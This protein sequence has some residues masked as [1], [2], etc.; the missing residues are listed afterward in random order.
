M[1]IDSCR[2]SLGTRPTP[3]PAALYLASGARAVVPGL[4]G[5][6]YLPIQIPRLAMTT[7]QLGQVVEA[8]AN[9]HRQRDRVAPLE[10]QSGKRWNDQLRFRSVFADLEPYD[11]DCYPFVVHTLER[12]P[13][14]SREQRDRAVREAG[15]NT[16]LL[17]SADVSIDLLTDSGT[18]AMS[19]DQWAAYD[20]ARA[21]PATSD[22]YLHFVKTFRE[23]YGYEHIIPTHQGRAAEHILSQIMIRSGP[24]RARQHVLH[25]NEGAPGIGRGRVRR[26]HRRSG[27]RSG[28]RI[29][30][31]G[32]HR[33]TKAPNLSSNGMARA[34]W[35]TS[36]S[37]T[38]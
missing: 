10:L 30:V 36:R 33:P 18:S 27:P 25:D 12:I 15:Y 21:T 32:K 4:V 17:R 29:P 26:R 20:A 22:A 13:E 2:I 24:V 6:R 19:I 16:F 14:T 35:P 23:T 8:I 34:A 37:S 9:I 11:F 7:W 1:P 3:W 5:S 28:E 31:E 38:A